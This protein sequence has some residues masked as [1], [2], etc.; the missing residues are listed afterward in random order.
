MSSKATN[1]K[2]PLTEQDQEVLSEIFS[3][4]NLEDIQQMEATFSTYLV[5]PLEPWEEQG[6]IINS[7]LPSKSS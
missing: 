3:Q 5:A 7:S 4:I 1:Y 6:W 2:L